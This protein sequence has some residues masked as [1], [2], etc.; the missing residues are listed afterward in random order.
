MKIIEIRSLTGVKP[1]SIVPISYKGEILWI[2]GNKCPNRRKR[3][4]L[5]K[6]SFVPQTSGL[7][8]TG[9]DLYFKSA[10]ACR[11]C[12]NPVNRSPSFF[13][14]SYRCIE[15]TS[16]SILLRSNYSEAFNCIIISDTDGKA[17]LN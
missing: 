6:P 8:E 5:T 12:R 1:P 10:H 4:I 7:G 2:I 11:D 15:L 3:N 17:V 13:I 16:S 9:P 14:T